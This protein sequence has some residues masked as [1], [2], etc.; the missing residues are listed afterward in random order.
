[1]NYAVMSSKVKEIA[2]FSNDFSSD[3]LAIDCAPCALLLV[4]SLVRLVRTLVRPI[5]GTSGPALAG[6][7]AAHLGLVRGLV[8]GLFDLMKCQNKENRKVFS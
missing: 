6:H 2:R 7:L 8:R 3:E 4:R 1:M 5:F